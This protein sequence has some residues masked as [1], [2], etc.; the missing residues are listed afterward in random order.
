MA[1]ARKADSTIR[2]FARGQFPLHDC[3]QPACAAHAAGSQVAHRPGSTTK[4]DRIASSCGRPYLPQL[5]GKDGADKRGQLSNLKRR[6]E[7]GAPVTDVD[8]APLGQALC[9]L[10]REHTARR[11][12]VS[13]QRT[14][15]R[16]GFLRLR[17]PSVDPPHVP[18]YHVHGRNHVCAESSADP[19]HPSSC[20]T[21][22]HRPATFSHEAIH[23]LRRRATESSG[24]EQFYR[25]THLFRSPDPTARPGKA[26]RKEGLSAPGPDNPFPSRAL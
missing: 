19:G 16:G 14:D 24:M 25:G 21:L 4:R 5:P 6:A 11:G 22:S 12:D 2:T 13:P 8:T 15:R 1:L 7:N 26:P 18:D 23:R 10:L 9:R 3:G 17:S 20:S